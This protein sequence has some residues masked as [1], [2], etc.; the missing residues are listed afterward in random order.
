MVQVTTRARDLQAWRPRVILRPVRPLGDAIAA[1]VLSDLAWK[2]S[3]WAGSRPGTWASAWVVRPSRCTLPSTV[4]RRRSP[5]GA[6]LLTTAR[7]GEAPV[8]V[9]VSSELWSA[10][11]LVARLGE[12]LPRHK[13]AVSGM[14]GC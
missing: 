12:T 7:H 14:S 2:R 5:A 13:R 3:T 9:G 11:S 6:A 4:W 1:L 8:P 10:R